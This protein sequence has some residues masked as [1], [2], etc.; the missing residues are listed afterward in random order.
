M[1]EL[2]VHT[3]LTLDGVMQAPGGPEE[4]SENGFKYGGWSA[5]FWDETLGE[6]MGAFMSKPFDLVLGRKTYDLFAGFWPNATEEE[7]AKPLN[8]ATKYVASHGKPNLSWGRS[9]HRLQR[10]PSLAP[11]N[12]DQTMDAI[13]SATGASAQSGQAA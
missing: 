9:V 12:T 4:D 10:L 2:V 13:L 7:V 5:P 3:F 11:R 6:E 1:R 8:D